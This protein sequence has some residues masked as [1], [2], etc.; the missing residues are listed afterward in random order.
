LHEEVE[1]QAFRTHHGSALP[2][3][4]TEHDAQ[5]VVQQVRGRVI[6]GRLVTRTAFT[7]AFAFRR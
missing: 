6:A 4:L 3:V 1:A 5:G 7:M 2:H